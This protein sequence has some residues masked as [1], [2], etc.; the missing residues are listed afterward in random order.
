MKSDLLSSRMEPFD[1]FWEAP[2]NVEK[3]F[4]TF[5]A[6]YAFN[7]LKYI[8]KDKSV[9]I[10]VVSCGY[11]YFV[12]LLNKNGYRNV[13]GIDSD[14]IKI[15][16]AKRKNLNCSVERAFEFLQSD[17]SDFDVII[18]EQEL[19]HLE[20]KEV[21]IFLE[22]C[23][24]KLK[25]NGLLISHS[26][27]G[28]NPI[29]GAEALAQNFD[30]FYMLTDYSFIQV[31]EYTKFKDPVIFPL[32]LYV[33]WKNPFNYILLVISALMSF[34]F[35]CAFILYGKKNKIFTKKIG[36]VAYKR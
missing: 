12:S 11:G 25:Q 8:P 23:Y 10:L 34:F 31:L 32:C 17:V 9:N 3:G 24:N 33:F 36:A 6:F 19:N 4:K 18:I 5:G 28:A 26:L 16:Y 29:T 15:D 20:K 22:L 1:S 13:H 14:S 35:R 2:L 27:N 30:H 7:Y 21:L